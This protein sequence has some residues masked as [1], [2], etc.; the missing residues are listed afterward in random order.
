LG[1]KA[2]AGSLALANAGKVLLADALHFFE[3]QLFDALGARQKQ[4]GHG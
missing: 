3:Q 4:C 2:R 1:F